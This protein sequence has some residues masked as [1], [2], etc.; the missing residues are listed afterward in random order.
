MQTGQS[1]P[2]VIGER[3]RNAVAVYKLRQQSRGFIGR[4]G[5]NHLSARTASRA[6]QERSRVVGIRA[7]I[8]VGIGHFRHTVHDVISKTGLERSE[9]VKEWIANP[10]DCPDRI[11]ARIVG[12]MFLTG[13]VRNRREPSASE[14]G[15]A[16]LPVSKIHLTAGKIVRV[17]NIDGVGRPTT[18]VEIVF[19]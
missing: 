11:A 19:R 9:Y 1:I 16:E 5:D 12:E 4:A 6:F 10:L 14:R 13:Q 3:R 2:I 15:R 17:L 8:T 18:L 7:T